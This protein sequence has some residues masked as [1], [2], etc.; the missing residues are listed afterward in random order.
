MATYERLQRNVQEAIPRLAERLRAKTPKERYE[1]KDGWIPFAIPLFVYYLYRGVHGACDAD[2]DA[3]KLLLRRI[4][5]A[6]GYSDFATTVLQI[7]WDIH[8]AHLSSIHNRSL[9]TGE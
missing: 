4:L 5:K 7:L 3:D 6:L 9:T 1:D 8:Y 2:A